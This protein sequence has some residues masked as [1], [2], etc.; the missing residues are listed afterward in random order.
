MTVNR[1]KDVSYK[2]VVMHRIADIRGG[3]GIKTSELVAG[4]VLPEGTPV[5]A[6][7]NGISTVLKTAKMF[8]EAAASATTYKVE[9]GSNFK[10]GDVITTA[11]G[12]A[13]YGI[14]AIDKSNAQYDVITVA[15]T[16]GAAKQGDVLVQAAA[17]GSSAKLAVVPVG[18]TG[19]TE[20]N[21]DVNANLQMDVWVIA[22]CEGAMIPAD[23]LSA[24][25]G[26]INL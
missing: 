12:K 4:G 3:V 8:A 11:V 21:I 23:A 26:V 20:I 17:A 16:I 1:K 2:K 9:K 18:V 25:K 24:M 5:G 10:S 19:T 22:V 14:T 13:A 6:P 15:T 7:V